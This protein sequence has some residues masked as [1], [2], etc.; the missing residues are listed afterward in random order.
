MAKRTVTAT[1]TVAAALLAATMALAPHVQA[2]APASA[3]NASSAGRVTG[4][5]RTTLVVSDIEKSV[6]FYQRVG[7]IKIADSAASDTDQGGVFGSADLPLTAD[8]K[9]SRIVIMR[10]PDE[11]SGHLALLWY[12]RPALPSARGNLVG[13]GIGDVI[14]GFE[15]SD[16]QGT[17]SRLNQAG[18]RFQ[19]TPVRFT[20]P[21]VDGA[22]LAGQHLLAYDPDGHMVEVSEM[23]RR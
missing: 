19:R 4:L 8:S 20:Q 10:A 5:Q 3:N 9:V 15:V 13:L 16:I 12:D 7:L 6:D 1:T 14:I 11:R 21:G 18:T 17:Y 22:T 23:D 2:G